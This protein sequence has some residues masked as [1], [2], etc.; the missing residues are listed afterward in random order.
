MWPPV[1]PPAIIKVSVMCHSLRRERQKAEGRRQGLAQ[2]DQRGTARHCC[3]LPSTFQDWKWDSRKAT[4]LVEQSPSA[5]CLLPF[6]VSRPSRPS[7]V[8]SPI[9]ATDSEECR[10]R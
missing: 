9:A 6:A 2:H 4:S 8:L 5:F 7:R 1:P 10:P 3:L